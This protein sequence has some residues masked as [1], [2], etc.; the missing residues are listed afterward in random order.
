MSV[1]IDILTPI[2]KTLESSPDVFLPH[3]TPDHT[4]VSKPLSNIVQIP[5]YD[6]NGNSYFQAG[7]VP[8]LVSCGLIMPSGFNLTGAFLGTSALYGF[9]QL[10]LFTETKTGSVI[11]TNPVFGLYHIVKGNLENMINQVIDTSALAD[12]YQFLVTLDTVNFLTNPVQVSMSGCPASLD[13]KKQYCIPFVK[14]AHSLPIVN[15]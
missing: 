7:D 1:I 9:P 10:A 12:K 13:T 14:V 8:E 3:F 5:L 4:A 6:G 2:C 15:S 11:S